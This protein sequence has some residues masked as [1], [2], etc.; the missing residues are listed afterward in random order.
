M[1][2]YAPGSLSAADKL[3]AQEPEIGAESI[4]KASYDP[5]GLVYE[6]EQSAAG[7]ASANSISGAYSLPTDGLELQCICANSVASPGS[8]VIT[9]GVT[10]EDDTETT[11][12]A[13]FA[14]PSF[15]ADQSDY[16]PLGTGVDLVPATGAAKK[17]KSVDSIDSI[18]NGST[19]NRFQVVAL[20]ALTSYFSVGCTRSKD[21]TLPIPSTV[22][23]PCGFNGSRFVKSG[24]SEPG[25]MSCEA[26]YSLFSDGLARLA[27]Q[28]VT[29]IVETRRQDRVLVERLVL[30]GWRPVPQS[31][32]GDGDDETTTTAEGL[33]ERFAFFSAS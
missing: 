8:I 15:A 12:T 29:A 3:L 27:G 31:P 32:K 13:T 18:T 1:S 30:G 22:P 24:R 7:A 10:D 16:F 26:A 9:F 2:L 20:P 28:K 17:I 23:I 25:N 19:G 6:I 4:V 21:I 33:F 14:A 11:A 5:L